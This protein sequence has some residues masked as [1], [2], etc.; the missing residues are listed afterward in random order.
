M[1]AAL[2]DAVAQL[3]AATGAVPPEPPQAEIVWACNV[4]SIIESMSAAESRRIALKTLTSDLSSLCPGATVRAGIGR[5][6]MAYFIDSRLGWLGPESSLHQ[7]AAANW[8]THARRTE[9]PKADEASVVRIGKMVR[10]NLPQSGGTGRAVVWIEG[11]TD[12]IDWMPAM[13]GTIGA[14]LWS[15]PSRSLPLLA[16][17]IAKRTTV[18]LAIAAVLILVLAV[19]PV[20]YRVAC[21]AKVETIGGR[22]I[23]SPFE[24]T[25]LNATVRPGDVV[26]A[27]Q[28]LLVLDGRPLRLEREALEAEI[29]QVNKE[30]DVA[31]ATRRIAEAQ[32]ADLRRQQL[33]RQLDLINDRLGHLDVVSPIDGVVVSGDLEKHVGSPLQRGQTVI[34]VAPMEKMVIEVEIPEHE[35]AFVEVGQDTRVKIDSVGGASVHRPL[36]EL[37]PSAE[38]RDDRNVFVGRIELDNSDGKLRPGMR[39]DATVYGPLRPWIWS[40]VRSGVERV[41][42]WVGY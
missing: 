12:S 39:G 35:I 25:L 28:V 31:L 19:W 13:V 9:D 26:T 18:M 23:A 34:E 5:G 29:G 22:F 20:H 24:A 37:Y 7:Q 32:Q 16:L 6:R 40:W 42:W 1:S 14:V 8:D 33:T 36:T 3:A 15:R 30:H 2:G 21:T 38:L 27:G 17:R 10:L 41:M 11:H 4:A